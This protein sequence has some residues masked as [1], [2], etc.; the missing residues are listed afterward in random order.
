MR[1]AAPRTGLGEPK[2][3][4]AGSGLGWSATE[5]C[6]AFIEDAAGPGYFRYADVP[7][8]VVYIGSSTSICDR[9][10]VVPA[11]RP[12]PARPPAIR[13]RRPR[14][15]SVA[16]ELTELMAALALNK[17]SLAKI[18]RVSRPT[19]YEWFD[20]KVPKPANEER[21]QGILQI[22]SRRAVTG[23]RPLNARFVRRSVEGGSQSLV[24]LL[25]EERIEADRVAGAIDDV[26]TLTVADKRRRS[27]RERRLRD[28]GFEEPGQ[29]QRRETLA[30]NVALLDWP[31]E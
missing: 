19:I 29:G 4:A 10:S 9:R 17:S 18:L 22:L 23:A 30:R 11:D 13:S 5:P 25:S 8:F 31:K 20:G 26:R 27:D 16:E 12:N 14:A 3:G 15:L 24:D 6:L 28:L 21:L 2:A 7:F 1:Q